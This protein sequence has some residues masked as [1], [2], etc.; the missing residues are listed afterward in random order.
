MRSVPGQK[1]DEDVESIVNVYL[2]DSNFIDQAKAWSEKARADRK[3]E[4][5]RSA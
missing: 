2:N 4:S 1:I 5:I 3:G